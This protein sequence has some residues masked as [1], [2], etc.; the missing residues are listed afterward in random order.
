[1]PDKKIMLLCISRMLTSKKQADLL[2]WVQLA[3]T[4]ESSVKKS[5]GIDVTADEVPSPQTQEYSC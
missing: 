3:Y 2:A 4:A 1:M 5:L